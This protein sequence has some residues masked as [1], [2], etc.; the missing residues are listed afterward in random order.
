MDTPSTV[1]N[2]VEVVKSCGRWPGTFLRTSM[3]FPTYSAETRR[4]IAAS[5][6]HVRYASLAL[7]LETVEREEIPGA[8][9]ELG[10]Y[11][12][13]TS[14]FIHSQLPRRILYLFDTFNGF[15]SER[16]RDLRFRN[17]TVEFVR[18][19]LGNC[20][21]VFFRVGIFPDTAR[22]LE[23]EI[24]SL[25]VLDADKYEPTLAGLDFFYPRMSRGGYMFIHDYNSPES[26][27]GVSRA[28]RQFLKGRREQTI[29]IPDNWGSVVFRKG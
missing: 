7:A 15:P 8:F 2:L 10:V 23:S 29:E 6:D 9:A 3:K 13:H 18:N 28:V 11:R 12:G 21:N 14:S 16:D 1:L 4:R 20:S 26:D 24:F 27:S 19:R 5:G 17:T 22:G 25:V